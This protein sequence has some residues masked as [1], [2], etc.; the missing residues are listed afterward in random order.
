[1]HIAAVTL[2]AA[3][4][5]SAVS[6]VVGAGCID[7][8]PNITLEQCKDLTVTTANFT[9]SKLCS[10]D[11]S[12]WNMASFNEAERDLFNG[13][14]TEQVSIFSSFLPLSLSI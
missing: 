9:A 12:N 11:L 8:T 14:T 1:M 6:A 4:L 10:E 5:L 13:M 7:L 3:L 2:L